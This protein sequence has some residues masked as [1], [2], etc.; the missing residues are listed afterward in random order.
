LPRAESGYRPK[1]RES[2][3]DVPGSCNETGL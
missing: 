3:G 1:A 2:I